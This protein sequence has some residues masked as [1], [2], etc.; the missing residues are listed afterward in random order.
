M[1][2]RKFGRTLIIFQCLKKEH[3]SLTFVKPISYVNKFL[4]VVRCCRDVMYGIL[5][6]YAAMVN[7]YTNQIMYHVEAKDNCT[8]R[9]MIC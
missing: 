3:C 1:I 4:T 6:V 9:Q 7:G 8:D 2:C 5:V